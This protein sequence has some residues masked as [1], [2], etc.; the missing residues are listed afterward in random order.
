MLK[1]F[2]KKNATNGSCQAFTLVELLVVISIIALLVSILLPALSKAR[3][4]A[5][6][7]VCKSNL[8]QISLGFN[9][10]ADDNNNRF[11]SRTPHNTSVYYA[12]YT[13]QLV[14]QNYWNYFWLHGAN[15]AWKFLLERD[16]TRRYISDWRVFECSSDKGDA[17]YS[18]GKKNL[19]DN[20]GTSYWYNCRDNFEDGCD[21]H[22][23]S[24]LG[25]N[26]DNIKGASEVIVLGDAGAYGFHDSVEKLR[27]LWHKPDQSFA[28]VVFADFHV[29]GVFFDTFRDFQNGP[30]WTFVARSDPWP[31]HSDDIGCNQNNW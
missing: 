29:E 15:P 31:E 19:Y 26:I 25:R 22:P 3:E 20:L 10:Y 28:N 21:Y 5:K 1:G 8:R 30:G 2:S 4:Q 6:S 7:V 27:F 13:E 14:G 16:T 24:L 9:Y 17:V 18:F 23:G 11:P 12:A